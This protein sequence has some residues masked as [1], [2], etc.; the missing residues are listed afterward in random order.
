MKN[1]RSFLKSLLIFR[2]RISRER[3]GKEEGEVLY[4]FADTIRAVQLLMYLP[5]P[6]KSS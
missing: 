5:S 1:F 4:K 3:I 2:A 6:V